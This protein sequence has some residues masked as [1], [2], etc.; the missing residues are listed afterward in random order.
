[1]VCGCANPLCGICLLDETARTGPPD[2]TSPGAPEGPGIGVRRTWL[3]SQLPQPPAPW[4]WGK[5]IPTRSLPATI[6]EREGTPRGVAST[7]MVAGVGLGHG[8]ATVW[9]A[10]AEMGLLGN[11]EHLPLPPT[12]PPQ[13]A[14]R[15]V[16]T[17]GCRMCSQGVLLP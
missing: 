2:A 15:R 11:A 1:M 13:R 8:L 3:W 5:C 12:A 17:V 10:S 7:G 14:G 6:C 9:A 4:P 16:G